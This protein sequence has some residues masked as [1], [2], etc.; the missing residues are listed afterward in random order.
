MAKMIVVAGPPGGGKSTAFGARY[1]S[2]LKIP[3][4]NIDERCKQLHGS[5]QKIPPQIRRQAN[6]E[7]RTFC[8]E[9]IRRRQTFGFET[10]LR[11]DF[12]I[13]TSRDAQAAGLET[14]MHYVAAPVETHIERV[15]ARAVAGG[16]AASEPRLRE[17][18]AAS[19][20]NLPEAA[21]AFD[22]SFVYD[23]SGQE[24]ILQL[25]VEHGQ[26]VLAETPLAAWLERGLEKFKELQHGDSEL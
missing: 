1:F 15:T 9:H 2:N 4:F 6:E 19:M 26:I 11:A 10:T 20:N 22:R 24:V 23:A 21:I 14:E 7:L 8:E 16:H 5:A 13:R 3:Y 18:Y 25:E 17:M 12:A